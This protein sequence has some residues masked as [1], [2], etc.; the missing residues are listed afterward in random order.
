V[1]TLVRSLKKG[2]QQNPAI[3][4]GTKESEREGK[5]NKVLKKKKK[6]KKVVKMPRG[7]TGRV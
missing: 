1:K 7:E 2:G 6:E 5:K 3:R 4:E